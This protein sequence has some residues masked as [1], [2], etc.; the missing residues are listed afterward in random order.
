[1]TRIVRLDLQLLVHLQER[2]GRAQVWGCAGGREGAAEAAEG[3]RGW[4]RAR[5]ALRPRFHIQRQSS[6]KSNPSRKTRLGSRKQGNSLEKRTVKGPRLK[7][8]KN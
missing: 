6:T 7:H 4:H 3:R 8:L 2:E 1:M 5:L